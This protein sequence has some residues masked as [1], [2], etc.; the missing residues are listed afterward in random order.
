L[1][2]GHVASLTA[3]NEL[4]YMLHASKVHWFD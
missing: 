3:F 4:L 2:A 1:G